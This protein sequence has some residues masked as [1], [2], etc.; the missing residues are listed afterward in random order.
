LDSDSKPDDTP[1]DSTT[2][3]TSSDSSTPAIP[4][5]DVAAAAASVE[6]TPPA[7]PADPLPATPPPIADTAA[8]PALADASLPMNGKP[9]LKPTTQP[10][11]MKI[12]P[13]QIIT[14]VLV[15]AVAL[16][17]VFLFF[18]QPKLGDHSTVLGD[19]TYVPTNRVNVVNPSHEGPAAAAGRDAQRKVILAQYLSA[20]TADAVNGF[21]PVT[22]PGVTVNVTDPTTQQPYFISPNTPTTVGQIQYVPGGS[23]T[24]PAIKP[25]KSGTRYLALVTLLDDG[26][27]T[28][29][30]DAK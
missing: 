7:V 1:V 3:T 21:Y 9:P 4:V 5:V 8:V 24:G 27:T 13:M 14:I 2:P 10:R 25:G 6:S 19:S 26:T 12:G 17:L 20:F 29:C 30:V 23:C 16:A 22:P 28:Y 18:I 11:Q 15:V